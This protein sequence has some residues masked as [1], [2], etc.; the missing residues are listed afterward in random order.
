LAHTKDLEKLEDVKK[1]EL[2]DTLQNQ[3][4]IRQLNLGMKL[5][6]VEYQADNTKAT[7]FYSADD[8]VGLSRTDQN[9]GQ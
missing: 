2:P 4:I 3:E 1:R 7:F 9:V 8:R 6:D 5:S